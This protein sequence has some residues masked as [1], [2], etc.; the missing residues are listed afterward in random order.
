MG[1]INSRMELAGTVVTF[2]GDLDTKQREVIDQIN[3]EMGRMNERVADMTILKEGIEKTYTD[4]QE[5]N[6]GTTSF[7][8]SAE[9]ELAAGTTANEE[10]HQKANHVH[11]Q[12]HDLFGKTE[13]TF[14]ENEKNITDL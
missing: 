1:D 10:T 3:V 13:L 6:A 5:L 9:A 12:V 14:P 7:A 11:S 8:E 2:I 4:L